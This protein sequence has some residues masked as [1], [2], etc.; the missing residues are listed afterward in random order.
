MSNSAKPPLAPPL[1]PTQSRTH[2]QLAPTPSRSHPNVDPFP[3][4]LYLTRSHAQ[5]GHPPQLHRPPT[6]N[7]GLDNMPPPLPSSPIALQRRLTRDP[8][9]ELQ[10]GV[11]DDEVGPP[12]EGG[13]DAWLCVA[14]AFFVLFCVFGFTTCFGQ[15][16]IY[17]V[18]HQLQGYSESQIAWLATVQTFLVFSG[19]LIA[20]RFF[21]SHGARILTVMG[22]TLSVA[23]LIALAFCKEYYQFILAHA[24]FGLSGSILYSPATAVVGHWFMRRRSTAVGIVVCGSGLAGVIYPIALKKLFDQTSYRNTLLI[25]AGM[26]AVLMLPAWFYLKARLPPRAPPPLKSLL[27]PWKD[28]KYT[29][30]VIGSCIVML[31]FFSPYFN[32][33]ILASSNQLSDNLS[34]YSI[35][36]LQAGSFFGRA[37]SGVLADAFGVWTIFITMT[38]GSSISIFAFWVASPITPAA[39]VVGLVAYGFFSGA[40][41]ALVAASTGAISPTREFGMRLGML[42]SLTSIPGLIGPVICGILVSS[43]G[44]IFKY[45]GIFIGCSHLVGVF[46]ISGPRLVEIGRNVLGRHRGEKVTEIREEMVQSKE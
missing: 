43:N 42:W 40:W 25:I 37:L 15:L 23:A 33:P 12:P 26:N 14:S 44:D 34:S 4:Q 17:Y 41:L 1:L 22:T 28:I 9:V 6:R 31:N 27:G 8:D 46:V 7:D 38:I 19:S 2:Y 20:G 3:L 18:A 21:D 32:A 10:M 39:A 24:A 11:N 30:L 16:K 13:K 5:G 36:I 45:A 29:C 35:P